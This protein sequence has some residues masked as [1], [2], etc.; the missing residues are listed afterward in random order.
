MSV[1]YWISRS[2]SDSAAWIFVTLVL[3]FSDLAETVCIVDIFMDIKMENQ[4]KAL[5]LLEIAGE[6]K[7][8]DIFEGVEGRILKYFFK[9]SQFNTW[10]CEYD[11]ISCL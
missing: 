11:K 6:D 9:I 8:T 10:D 1:S 3:N 7:E 4:Y 5:L 2:I